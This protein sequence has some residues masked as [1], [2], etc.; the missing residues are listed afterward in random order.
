MCHS[1]LHRAPAAKSLRLYPMAKPGTV[2][3]H[4][5]GTAAGTAKTRIRISE[6]E[7][8]KCS[9]SGHLLLP[10]QTAQWLWLPH[11]ST[12]WC[13]APTVNIYSLFLIWSTIKMSLQVVYS[14]LRTTQNFTSNIP[15]SINIAVKYELK[16]P[17][18]FIY[19][20]A[21]RISQAHGES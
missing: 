19:I 14:L 11:S 8:W 7:R 5:P 2:T 16:C 6:K 1:K 20:N 21:K 15:L 9:N 10:H 18:P 12:A 4:P 13:R 17:A 3:Q